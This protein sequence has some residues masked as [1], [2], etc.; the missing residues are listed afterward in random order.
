MTQVKTLSFHVNPDHPDYGVAREH[1]SQSRV[2]RN[3]VNSVARSSYFHYLHGEDADLSLARIYGFDKIIH[4]GDFKV[5]LSQLE[6][7]RKSVENV[8]ETS[9]P[10]KVSQSVVRSLLGSWRSFYALRKQGLYARIPG[11]SKTYHTAEYNPQAISRKRLKEGWIVP[12]GWS[13][14]FKIPEG[15]DRVK[16]ARVT[17]EGNGFVLRV[18]YESENDNEYTPIP[19][20]I[21]GIDPGVN[22]LFT[23]SFNDFSEGIII[24]GKPMKKVN[25]HYNHLIS[26]LTSKLDIERKNISRKINKGVNKDNDDYI[27]AYRKSSQRLESLWSKRNRKIKHYYTTATNAT[28]KAL[29]EAGVETVVIGW[30]KENKQRV[31]MGKRNNRNFVSIPLKKILDNLSDKLLEKGIKVIFTEES[32]TSKSSFLDN[33]P[34]PVYGD[35]Q[36]PSSFSGRRV[37]RGLYR[38]SDG[39][40]IN[41]D[42][43]GSYNI[44]RKYDPQFRLPGSGG[45]S[46]RSTGAGTGTVVCQVKRVSFPY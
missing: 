23:I 26:D 14:G 25:S 6:S 30:N 5:S 15:Y 11:Y 3:G 36:R 39:V 7:V 33:D 40:F 10:Q 9:L 37:R 19:G 2:L 38:S 28:V 27:R 13:Q 42:L 12:T 29:C 43:N 31:N 22:N 18:L 32:Y 44:I 46:D 8:Q 20:K 34:L 21:A 41:A 16:S 35:G 1:C 45:S 4:K 17:P 24:D